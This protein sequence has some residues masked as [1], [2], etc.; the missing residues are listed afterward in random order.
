M[1]RL[2][3]RTDCRHHWGHWTF[4]TDASDSSINNYDG[5]LAGDAFIDS[6]DST[7][8]IGD[9]KLSL[10]GSSDYVDLSAH[11]SS[12]SN[13]TE[14]TI[15]AWI[16]TTDTGESVIFDM[17]DSDG[18]GE[19]A[20]FSIEG[21]QL[22]WLT[23]NDTGAYVIGY[24][25]ALVNDGNWHH[26]AVT[27]GPSGNALYIDGVVASMTYTAGDSTESS[28]LSD[29]TGADSADIGRS[30]YSGSFSDYNGLLDDVRLYGEVLTAELA[31]L[32][33]T[34]KPPVANDDSVSTNVDT[35]VV[36][37]VVAND[38]DPESDAIIVVDVTD[39]ANGS[40]VDNGDG[41]ITYTPD[42]AYTGSDSFE[43]TII[44][45][46]AG[47]QHYW[48]FDGNADDGVGS[49]NGTL[50]GTT[51][52]A[53][54]SGNGL[55]FNETSDQ[56]NIPDV[57]YASEFSI[58][59]DFK[60]DDNS[61]SLFQY[62]Y[63]HG[64]INSTNSVNIFL[65]ESSH[66]TD[67][68]VLR[69]VIRD[70]DDTLD[71]LALQIDIASI[72]GDGNWHNYTVTVGADGIEVY[73]DGVLQATDATR[74]TGTINPAGD[75]F[76]GVRQDLNADRRYGGSLDSLQIYNTALTN[77]QVTDISSGSNRATVNITVTDT[78]SSPT[79]SVPSAQSTNEDS[80]LIFNTANSNLISIDDEAGTDL[81]V[82]LS[83]SNGS[84]TL[85][86][87]TGITLES[88]AYGSSTMTIS[89]TVE[90]INTALDGLQYLPDSEYSGGDTLSITTIDTV[91]NE[92][93]ID[94]NLQGYYEFTSGSAGDDSSPGGT[95]GGTLN[96]DATV[97]NDAE[98]GD[99]ISV[100]GSGD[101][102]QITG[103]FS[104]PPNV[105]LAAWVNVSA[106]S[107]GDIISLGDNVG[108]TVNQFA[109]SVSGLFFNGT[110]WEYTTESITIDGDGWHHVAYVF[111]DTSN[112]QIL[113]I[114]GVAAATTNSTNSIV[115]ANGTN[116]FIG[117][118]GNGLGYDL[119]GLIDDVRVYDQVLTA[120]DIANLANAPTTISDTD[121][122]SITVNAANDAP[123]ATGNTVVA[124]EDIPL[125]IGPSDFSF[126]DVEGDSLQSVVITGLNLNGGTLTHS[127]GAVTVTNG[128][129]ITAAQLA[130][131]TFT[132]ASNDSTNSS[133]TYTVNDADLGVTSATMNI[134]VNAANDTPTDIVFD[135][136]IKLN[137]GAT[138]GYA[139]VTQ[140]NYGA[141]ASTQISVEVSFASTTIPASSAEFISY[142]VSPGDA[143]EI[144]L[145]M[146]SGG[147]FRFITAGGS[148][149]PFPGFDGTTL[150]DGNQHQISVT[151]DSVTG[152]TNLYADGVLV[153]T[154]TTNV[155]DNVTWAT[156]ADTSMLVFGQDQDSV[157][158][159]FNSGEIF[160]GDIFEARIYDDIRTAQEI[161]DNA[162]N[163][164]ANPGADANLLGNWI[165][166]DNGSGM[167]SDLAGSND[168][169]LFGT[170]S[171]NTT[172]SVLE[173]SGNGSHVAFVTDV[174]DVDTGDTHSFSLT[175][176]A[177]G[178]FAI[179]SSTG[180]ITVAN[181]NLIDYESA[182]S[183]NITVRVTDG[184]GLTYDEVVTINVMNVNETP[185]N[186]V[187]GAQS[188]DEDTLLAIGGI[189]VTD[190][191]GN[192][193]ST[194]LTVTNGT[195]NVSLVGGA[196]ISS[197]A[198]GSNTITLNGTEA[199]INAALATLTYQGN[200]NYNGSDT[201]TVLSTDSG[202]IPLSDSDTVAITV[203][204]VNN[205][206][207]D[208][209]YTQYLG[210]S[211]FVVNTTTTDSQD[212]PEVVT[213]S[214]GTFVV[215]WEST[216][217]D[218]S[219]DG[220]YFQIF[221]ANGVAQG[222]EV[223]ANVTTTGDQDDPQIVALS[224]GG[225]AIIWESD[226]QDGS[227]SGIFGRI[228]DATG[229]PQTGEFS[230]NTTTPDDQLDPDVAALTGGG[231]VVVWESNLQDG[232]GKGIYSQIFDN[233]G[234]TIGSETLVNTTTAGGQFDPTITA[235][236]DGGYII[237][238]DSNDGSST[239]LMSQRFD[240][241][242]TKI[243]TE[244][245]IN[246]F[247]I[248][249][250]D[251]GVIATLSGG[252]YV[253]VWESQE[254]DGDA[255]GLFGQF[256]DAGGNPVGGEFS[257]NSTTAGSQEDIEI[258]ALS[259]GG[260]LV[261]WQSVGGQDGDADGIYAQQF[262]ANGNK[263]N[264]EFLVNLTTTNSQADPSITLLQ[265]GRLVVVYE[266]FL[267]DGSGDSVIGRIFTPTLNEN[268]PNGTVAAVLSQTIDVDVGDTF[269]YSL[270]DD[271]GGAFTINSTTGTIT[272]ADTSLIDYESATMMTVTVRVTDSGGLT[273]DEV[274]TIFINDTND[275][276]VATGN[277]VVAT[278]DIP[279]IIGAGSF[280]FTDQD[281]DSLQSIT[282]TGLNLNGG[283][284]THSGG[285]VTVTNG[286]TVTAAELADL[287]FTSALNDSTN[288]SF[289]YT[290][291]DAE[292]GVVS[293]TLNITVNAVN[294]APVNTVPGAQSVDEDTALNITGISVTDVDGNL[295]TTQ[296]TVSNGA[297]NVSLAGGATIS[298]GANGSNTLTLSGTEAQINAALATLSYQGNLNFNGSDT[299]TVLSTDSDGTPLSDT[300]N[301]SITVN[302]VNDAPVLTD[303]ATIGNSEGSSTSP[304]WGVS[305]V[306][307][308]DSADFDGGVL[309]ATISAGGES[310]DQLYFNTSGSVSLSG[311]SILVGGQII[312]TWTGGTSGT[313]L[314][315]TFNADADVNEVQAVYESITFR[316]NS[317][318]PTEGIRTISVTL[319]DGDGGTSNTA[320]ASVN[321]SAVNDEQVLA[322]NTGS[323]V[324]EG[325][326]GNVVTTAMLETTDVDNTSAQLVYTVDGIP[327]N[328]ILYNNGVALAV[329]DTFTQ[330]DID[331]GLITYD[332][333]GSQTTADGFDFTVDD[334]AGTTTSSSFSWTVTNTNDAPVNTVPGAQ[335]V[336]EDTS[337]NITGISVNDVD[338]NLA[339]TQLTR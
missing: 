201:L 140:F 153:S 298:A 324:A 188:V 149:A 196:S 68:D 69:T 173:N 60:L 256:F 72:I 177:G 135:D 190:V 23:I 58:S 31:E 3:L 206:P 145:F 289:T 122:V 155:G 49:S 109:N 129:T 220:V 265:D 301:V 143:N 233:S 25:D 320:T 128:M 291:N 330:A 147:D 76:I 251:D 37:D 306:A 33:I 44:D 238:W 335:S 119:T 53:G 287:T 266:S 7:D 268:S 126:T 338:G 15:S 64:D 18:T 171:F 208:L 127:G 42:A 22:K 308:A 228:Y 327:A 46:T 180:E 295:A 54:S 227:L 50:T 222:S 272:I 65:N 254:Q 257:I 110:S 315:I 59:F 88:G 98:H 118:D 286:M 194:Q 263:I 19:I 151:W 133:F 250:Q 74:G 325:S 260:F 270:T 212:E 80:V 195:L 28:F 12:F 242:G 207:T 249:T 113:Y 163:S 95:N 70:S 248:D 189:S 192:L 183:M 111:D 81:T 165:M 313:P 82:T 21:G 241:S 332:H 9:A 36:I 176:S 97:V 288:S 30:V 312:G 197:G 159:G 215:V 100:D 6:T 329:N 267:Q 333:D 334:G 326:T 269:T 211:E 35:A 278:E 175:D 39:P 223:R 136:G 94:A 322:T 92:L 337:L 137:D 285:T 164:L 167:I 121:T 172:L 284:L 101:S 148:H 229:T 282:I 86:G 67:P 311:S 305:T 84:L 205:A 210:G 245:Q 83:V 262:D 246:T 2:T 296:L 157:G 328:G 71:N 57:T 290:V 181:T 55:S 274:V 160:I 134:T 323:T 14:G 38:A 283:T 91:I 224:D 275:L 45:S 261:V 336:D 146:N 170:A 51:T 281:S 191:D 186:T 209:H 297:L 273:H 203:N 302:V 240:A 316:T 139:G 307:D 56:V 106:G 52:V 1:Y 244:S 132:S 280:S 162:N 61:G 78:N 130:T 231:F 13:I 73:L 11:I 309:T 217:Q 182:T 247:S 321:L 20:K 292:S 178:A 154:M 24:S 230:I 4:D 252:G 317:D 107:T 27:V 166:T 43:Y 85:S 125:I 75:V 331:A 299:L 116:T 310:S 304:F 187:P 214:N 258:I 96:G 339:T 239:E 16:N 62:L 114:D 103:M 40:V 279:L 174:I 202:G 293:A 105:T 253:A 89:G 204:A 117:T 131:L 32:A 200:T 185:V 232:D 5:T 87:T 48:G 90:D 79:N 219:G 169:T 158:G 41:T 225:F 108:I 26:V 276:P 237:A 123:E 218:G 144:S 29:I 93:N 168:L 142:A 236:N 99:V 264:G 259:D 271:A 198:N 104:N 63:S 319:T 184:G 112:T 199:Q 161:A 150:F 213:L 10:D 141:S 120:T 300:D 221:D 152:E 243:G 156:G 66:G 294:D 193:V 303:G 277:T 226:N 115:Y 235:L 124:T 34:N 179:N 314:A 102:V 77:D 138:D 8:K 47:A 255:D 17:T 234:A 318:N 216:N